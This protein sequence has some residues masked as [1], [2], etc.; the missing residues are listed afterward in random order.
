MAH[1]VLLR[2]ANVGGHNR[3][4]PTELLKKLTD[5]DVTSHGAA[6]T[7]V[8]R[9][10]IGAAALRE[11]FRRALPFEC[12]IIVVP[13]RAFAR[14][15]PTAG[16]KPFVTVLARRPRPAPLPMHA[17]SRKEWQTRIDRVEGRIVLSVWRP[18]GRRLIYP[19]E[20]VEKA[21]G[22]PATTR[23]WNTIAEALS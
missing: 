23:T 22:V 2:G 21:F 8:V 12:E 14:M 7:F 18:R 5:L 19:N 20:V 9:A 13:A 6:G 17:P 3:F 1:V 16:G 15:S 10:K 11:R 4:R